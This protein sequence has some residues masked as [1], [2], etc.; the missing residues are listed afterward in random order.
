MKVVP[1]P[2]SLDSVT[3]PEFCVTIPYTAARPSPVPSPAALVVKNG[4]KARA[5]VAA[6]MPTPLSRTMSTA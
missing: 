4:S 3:Y 5:W 1:R 2:G 6:S